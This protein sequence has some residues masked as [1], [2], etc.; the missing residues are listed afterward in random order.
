MSTYLLSQNSSISKKLISSTCS[1]FYEH[2]LKG[3]VYAKKSGKF[4]FLR[5]RKID[6]FIFIN[7]IG[8]SCR[9]G[10]LCESQL[11]FLRVYCVEH[12][13]ERRTKFLRGNIS[14]AAAGTFIFFLSFSHTHAHKTHSHTHT[15]THAH[16]ISFSPTHPLS[17]THK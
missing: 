10:Q 15:R 5:S 16:C 4:S 6:R 7:L 3:G 9:T 17:G 1:S 2:R 12:F 13:N 11:T 14:V 8:L